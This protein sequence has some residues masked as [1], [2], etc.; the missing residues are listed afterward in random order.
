MKNFAKPF[1]PFSRY[2]AFS[3][4]VSPVFLFTEKRK[5][6]GTRDSQQRHL[7]DYIT[8]LIDSYPVPGVFGGI[9]AVGLGRR[10]FS[11]IFEIARKKPCQIVIA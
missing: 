5:Q 2:P 8:N 7:K 11:T 10:D 4:L 3:P 1:C 9:V 6:Y